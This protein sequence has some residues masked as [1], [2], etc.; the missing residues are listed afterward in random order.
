MPKDIKQMDMTETM[1]MTPRR[2]FKCDADNRTMARGDVTK[3][4]F[5]RYHCTYCGGV[6]RDV[7]NTETGRDFM[8]IINL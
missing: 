8:E 1:R 7:T 4:I 6:V 2:V 5:G 3:D